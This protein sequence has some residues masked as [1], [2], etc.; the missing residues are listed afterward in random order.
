[1]IAGAAVLNTAFTANATEAPASAQGGLV[2]RGQELFGARCALCHGENGRGIEDTDTPAYG[3][4]LI[5]VGPASVDFMLRTGRMPLENANQRLR[6]QEPKVTDEEREALIAFVTSLAPDQGPE[7]PDVEAFGEAD[8]ARG[9]ELFTTNCAA[10]HGP[11]AQGIAVGQRDVSSTL[12]QATPLEVAEAIRTG[13][14]VMPV[15]S[16]EALPQDDVEALVA[17]VLHLRDREAPGGAA[18]GRSGPVSEGF[19]AWTLG[20]GLLTVIMY[21]LGEKSHGDDDVE[22]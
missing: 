19:I 8:L 9:M 7:I 21:L 13:P 6:H 17:W 4:S 15:F 5:G 18:I 3:P 1:M 12:D 20:L 2:E 10:C 14:G 11:T 16:D 22:A